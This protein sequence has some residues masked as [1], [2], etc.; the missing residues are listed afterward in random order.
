MPKGVPKAGYRMTKNRAG[1]GYAPK[2]VLP[3]M[4]QVQESP[5]TDE[6]ISQLLTDRFSVMTLMSE[7]TAR[8]TNRA[9]IISGPPGLGKSFGV[10]KLLEKLET[11]GINYTVI[12]GFV[13]TTGLYK[14]LY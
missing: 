6:E 2:S 1:M 9:L 7:A 4:Q 8:G 12:R 11:Q 10:F 3:V 14:T 5:M 13:R